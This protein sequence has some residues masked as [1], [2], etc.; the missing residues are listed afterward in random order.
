MSVHPVH[1][2]PEFAPGDDL[3]AAVAG[4]APWLAD[5][6]VVVVTS[7]VVAKVE[8]NLVPVPPG[9]DREAVRLQAVRE[10]T[11]RVVARRGPLSIVQTRHGWVIAAAGIDASNVAGDA[12]VLLPD[13][14]D[15]SA[16]GLRT[17][18]RDLLGVDVA[19]VVSDT[20]GRPWRE[21]LT[22]VAVG[23]AGIAALT[24]YRGRVDPHGNELQTTQVA[25]VDEIAAAADLVKDKLAGVPVA[26][27]RG[28][29]VARPDAS[30]DPGTRPLVRLPD[31]DLFPYG[32]RDVVPSRAPAGDLVP[33]PG[34][35]D[36]VAAAVRAA[37]AALPEFPV[38]LRYG[39]EGDGVV[40]VHLTDA[41]TTTTALNLGALLGAVIVQLHAEGWATRWEPVGPPG[42]SSLVGRLWLGSRR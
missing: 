28:L 8:G 23:A 18:L 20:F 14:A 35:L 36:A 25:V 22:D 4:A 16:R 11:V 32:A 10:Q 39:G 12:L 42:G 21:G 26:V 3:A 15:A 29:P 34:E 41:V 31:E 6:D 33:R 7:K 2:L 5:G 1:G 27:V 13:D 30:A 19:V 9:A 37:T 40:D 17:R 24:D 38:V